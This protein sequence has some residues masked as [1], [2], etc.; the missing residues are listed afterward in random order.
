MKTRSRE[1]AARTSAATIT[2]VAS[3]AVLFVVAVLC[4][5]STNGSSGSGEREGPYPPSRWKYGGGRYY[6]DG[7]GASVSPPA[8]QRRQHQARTDEPRPARAVED[9]TESA[10]AAAA[11]KP[12]MTPRDGEGGWNTL[13]ERPATR[14]A[15]VSGGT[16]IGHAEN[17]IRRKTVLAIE[18]ES[19]SGRGGS[20]ASVLYS[21]A[22]PAHGYHAPRNA[23]VV[24][25]AGAGW[26]W[27]K[28][29]S[30]EDRRQRWEEAEGGGGGFRLRGFQPQR[31][32]RRQRFLS[33]VGEERADD[34]QEARGIAPA[35]AAEEEGARHEDGGMVEGRTGS[36]QSKHPFDKPP[37]RCFVAKGEEE[38]RCHANIFF[39]GVSKC[40]TTSLAH[41]MG[42]HP[43]VGTVV[44]F[45]VELVE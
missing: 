35:V 39:F 22:P 19:E 3:A 5:C 10:L 28:E 23:V 13:P 8:P 29:E 45:V 14:R 34:E 1:A 38:T 33:D 40:G 31:Q 6:G 44:G 32:Q 7:G 9:P 37:G 24:K 25:E 36:S 11:A 16:P 18:R 20:A 27:T 21:R 41:W 42:E 26:A 43:E 12:W 30:S 15:T 17:R 2:A 4:C